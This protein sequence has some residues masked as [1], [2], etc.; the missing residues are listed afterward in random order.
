MTKAQPAS[1][2]KAI[3]AVWVI[4]LGQVVSMTGL[5][6]ILEALLRGHEHGSTMLVLTLLF[7]G[8]VP[9]VIVFRKGVAAGLEVIGPHLPAR[10]RAAPPDGND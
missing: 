4:V 1:K 6:M 8:Q 3:F 5:G 7:G 9:A 10:F 2:A